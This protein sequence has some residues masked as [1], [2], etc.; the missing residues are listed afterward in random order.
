MDRLLYM[1]FEEDDDGCRIEWQDMHGLEPIH[2][3]EFLHRLR[4]LLKVFLVCCK[5]VEIQEQ[6]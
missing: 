1:F 2:L 5:H 6:T 3:D 4:T